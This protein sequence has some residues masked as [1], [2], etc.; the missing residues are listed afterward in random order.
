MADDAAVQQWAGSGEPSRGSQL[1][2]PAAAA[3]RAGPPCRHCHA[4]SRPPWAMPTAAAAD[5]SDPGACPRQQ[6]QQCRLAPPARVHSSSDGGGSP[7]GA[8]MMR[9]EAARLF[10]SGPVGSQCGCRHVGAG[11]CVQAGI[12]GCRHEGAGQQRAPRLPGRALTQ[13]TAVQVG[14]VARKLAPVNNQAAGRTPTRQAAGGQQRRSKGLARGPRPAAKLPSIMHA[15]PAVQSNHSP[16]I[17]LP[18]H[19]S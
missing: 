8:A 3:S 17:I 15:K 18:P 11:M 10:R 14:Q 9:A 13:P 7:E 19:S 2:L 5:V 6:P 4:A 12:C 1:L 16:T